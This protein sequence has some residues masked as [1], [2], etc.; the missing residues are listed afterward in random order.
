MIFDK[1]TYGSEEEFKVLIVLNEEATKDK[2]IRKTLESFN[3]MLK[4]V[5]DSNLKCKQ[6][7][8]KYLLEDYASQV[9]S[10]NLEDRIE[11]RLKNFFNA[12]IRKAKKIEN[13]N[14]AF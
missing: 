12:K 6:K 11:T 13:I 7:V 4:D 14:P 8:Y 5:E 1:G 2:R 3:K 10:L 9:E